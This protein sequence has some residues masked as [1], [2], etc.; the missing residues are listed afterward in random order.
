MNDEEEKRRVN[1]FLDHLFDYLLDI[2]KE[3]REY[4]DERGTRETN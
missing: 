3:E 1:L 2:I 4:D